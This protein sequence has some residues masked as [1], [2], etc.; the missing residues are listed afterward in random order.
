MGRGSFPQPCASEQT[1]ASVNYYDNA[2]SETT[3][4]D[5]GFRES[6]WKWP[7]GHQELI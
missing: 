5:D 2:D 7:I 1:S 6:N 3:E 4:S